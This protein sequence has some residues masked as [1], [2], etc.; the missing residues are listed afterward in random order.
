MRVIVGKNIHGWE[1]AMREIKEQL[2]QIEP[3]LN[4]ELAQKIILHLQ[5]DR[6]LPDLDLQDVGAYVRRNERNDIIVVIGSRDWQFGP[7]GELVG[8]GTCI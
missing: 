5:N 8:Q 7:T 6:I 1:D 4:S 2:S 3:A